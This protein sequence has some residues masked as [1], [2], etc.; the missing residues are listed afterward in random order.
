MDAGVVFDFDG[1]VADSEQLHYRAY[2]EVLA[3]F[4]IVVDR[5]VYG[6]I[7]IGEGRGPEW[8]VAEHGLSIAPQEIVRRKVPVYRKLLR[9]EVRLMPGA[10]EALARIAASF[11]T[12]LATN[13]RGEDVDLVLSRFDLREQF[14]AVVTREAYGRPKPAPDAFLAA[15]KALDLPPDRCLVVEDAA[16]GVRAAHAAGCPCV[17]VP[18]D[19]TRENDFSLATRVLSGIDELVPALVTELLG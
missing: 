13:S 4:G 1:V 8:A 3:E 12:A 2:S 6:R 19:F 18:H 16:K 9:E 5:E 17:A 7:W 11:R 10:A 15:A 14:S